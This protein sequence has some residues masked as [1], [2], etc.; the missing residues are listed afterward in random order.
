MGSSE[1][2]DIIKQ[3]TKP[4]RLPFRCFVAN[5]KKEHGRPPKIAIDAFQWLFECGFLFNVQQEERST[6]AVWPPPRKAVLNFVTKLRD[7]IS[8]DLDFVLVFDGEEKPAYKQHYWKKRGSGQPTEARYSPRE[9]SPQVPQQLHSVANLV[10]GICR[11]FNVDYIKATGEGEAQCAALQAAGTVDYVLTNDSDAAIFGASKI[12]RNFSK[13]GQDLPSSGVSPVKKH[14]TDYFVTVVD[15]TAGAEEHPTFSRKAFTLFAILT[16][17]DYGTGLQHL[18]YK[19]A[20]ALTQWSKGRFANHFWNMCST[21]VDDADSDTPQYAT[22]KAVL[23]EACRMHTKEI[24]GQE[25]QY[26]RKEHA[27]DTFLWPPV[28]VLRSYY[29][30]K[31]VHKD[32]TKL[33][34]VRGV[35]NSSTGPFVPLKSAYSTL[36]AM[37]IPSLLKDFDSWYHLLAHNCALLKHLL[38]DEIED[39]AKITEEKVLELHRTFL[40]LWKVRYRS[41]LTDVPQPPVPLQ[42]GSPRK[43]SPSRRQLDIQTFP[44]ALWIAQGLLPVSH[45][46]VEEFRKAAHLQ[47]SPV[48]AGSQTHSPQKRTLDDF[49]DQASSPVKRHRPTSGG[50]TP[51]ITLDSDDSSFEFADAPAVA[52]TLTPLRRPFARDMGGSTE[53]RSPMAD[54]AALACLR[55]P[56]RI[57]AWF[58]AAFERAEGFDV[59]QTVLWRRYREFLLATTGST[60]TILDYQ[61]LPVLLEAVIPGVHVRPGDRSGRI[62]CGVRSTTGRDVSP[63][64]T[65]TVRRRLSFD[66]SA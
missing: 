59:H 41:F 15:I 39:T 50:K 65:R 34:F 7:F 17:A 25:L 30:P 44:Y 14:L 24:F 56:A 35:S 52:P 37:H 33:L 9:R 12:L 2:W 11:A 1:L 22:F 21:L 28:V 27:P 20:W 62:F 46:L 42:D 47:K 64:P 18:G 66:S 55:E 43:R 45:P 13:Y 38:Y 58:V 29:N 31:V 23:L 16:G 51:I 60:E 26:F 40:P 10:A 57:K 54:A 61:D 53:R 5:F 63:N 8:L 48:K 19:R 32:F 36:T 49:L 6:S 3:Y 4:E